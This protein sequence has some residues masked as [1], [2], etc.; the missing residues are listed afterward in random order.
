MGVYTSCLNYV[1]EK[2]DGK[3]NFVEKM[4]CGM[5]GG[6]C[7][8]VVGNPAEITL[9]RTSA[10]NRLPPEQRRGYTNCI[11]AIYRIC[12]EEGV[13][14]LWK[15]TSATVVRAMVLNAAQLGGYSQAKEL[16]KDRWHLFKKDGLGLHI[17]SSLTSGLFCTI[18]SLPVDI[19]KTRL[20]MM[21]CESI[22]SLTCR[23]GEYNGC[24]DCV[25]KLVSQE[26]FFALWKGFTPYFFRLGPHTI[27]TF[28]FLE[29]LN[30]LFGK[31]YMKQ[32]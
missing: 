22:P 8:A 11:Q 13:K 1:K 24:M 3:I 5:I 19:I 26:G 17:A 2:N 23:G 7:G 4:L 29:Q 27:L 20:Q 18:V 16:Y 30:K 12:K 9:I 25:K 28:V 14:T 21:K 6:A 10:D 31:Y 32:K 15:G